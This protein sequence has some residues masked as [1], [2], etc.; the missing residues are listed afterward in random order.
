MKRLKSFKQYEKVE[1]ETPEVYIPSSDKPDEF[2]TDVAEV[3]DETAINYD[4]IKEWIK[5]IE[6]KLREIEKELRNYGTR[7][8]KY[9]YLDVHHFID[10][11]LAILKEM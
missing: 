2:P 11:T 1:T 10:N 8:E 3:Q 4:K 5:D 6:P 9:Q 7:V